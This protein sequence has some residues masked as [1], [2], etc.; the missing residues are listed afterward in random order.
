M[1]FH[2]FPFILLLRYNLQYEVVEE[3]LFANNSTDKSQPL[4][5]DESQPFAFAFPSAYCF[6]YYDV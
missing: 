1:I 2:R 5:S 4:S 3:L 6:P